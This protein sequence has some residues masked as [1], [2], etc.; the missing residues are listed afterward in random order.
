[1]T[2]AIKVS[3]MMG[4]KAIALLRRLELLDKK[5]KIKL[6]DSNALLIPLI[7]AP[8]EYEKNLI[9]KQLGDVDFIT[10]SFEERHVRPKSLIEALENALTPSEL[11]CLPRSFDIIGDIA[12]I[13]I[14][15]ELSKYERLIGE[16]IIKVHPRVKAV[17][18]KAGPVSG[19]FRVRELKHIYGEHR[20]VTIHKEFGCLFKVD[21]AR[22]YFSPRLST[23][24][25]R[26]SNQARSG[27]LIVDMFAGVGPFSIMIAKKVNATV[28][29]CDINRYAIHLL[30]EN[31]KLNK[32]KGEVYPILGDSKAIFMSCKLEN[33]VDRVIMNL[34]EK[35]I[36]YLDVACKLIKPGGVV[37]YYA[38]AGGEE[39]IEE[40]VN[41]VKEAL[42]SYWR[43]TFSII[44][45]RMIRAIA[46]KKWQVVLDIKF[47][48]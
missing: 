3:K 9:R 24:H 38:F 39:P 28:I 10:S 15:P 41:K 37:H 36:E 30:N 29:A 8:D 17:F 18:S 2:Q 25:N 14:P 43:G 47:G 21:I 33:M 40:A 19:L 5:K 11:A 32:L 6:A 26:V 16:A 34:P 31:I 23:E 42:S 35:A 45:W 22:T 48:N 13:E 4:D 7:R 46:P 1:M 12:I 20:T 27:E 44:N